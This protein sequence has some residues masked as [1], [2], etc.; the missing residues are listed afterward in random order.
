M[1]IRNLINLTIIS[2]VFFNTY[3][4]AQN[5]PVSLMQLTDFDLQS[6]AVIPDNGEVI[7]GSEFE[8]L[9]MS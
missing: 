5:N 4:K 9:K 3:V 6:S 1:M 7:S 8:N 2:G